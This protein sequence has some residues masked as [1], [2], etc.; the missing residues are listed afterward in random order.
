MAINPYTTPAQY[1]Y[2]P[3]NLMAFAEPLMKMQ[4][5]FDLTKAALE[6]S[7]VKAT[8]LQFGEDP[9]RAKELE[10]IYRTKRDELITNLMET[11]NYTQAASKLK[12]LNKLYQQD[13]ERIA[14]ETN[15]NTF[16][17]RDKEEAA[18][19]GKS[20]AQGGIT[21][22]QY[23]Q[24]RKEEIRKFEENQ[25]TNY[26]RD[27][28]NPLGTYNPITGKVGRETDMSKEL[29]ELMYKVAGD[30]EAKK[31]TS[32][33]QSLGIDPTVGDAKFKVSDY[34]KLSRQ[35]IEAKVEEYI[36]QQD[37]FKPFL[38]EKAYYD[39]NDIL[40]KKDEGAAFN[41][42]AD[43]LVNRNLNASENYLKYLES[44][45]KKKTPEYE[46]ALKTKAF[47][48]EQL[49]NPDPE[50]IRKLFTDSEMSRQYDASA[51]GKIFEVNN[52]KTNYTFR[53]LP[54]ED[55]GGDG[56]G[57]LFD[58]NAAVVNPTL[59]NR[60]YVGLE[61]T[62]NKGKTTAVKAVA[63]NNR[64]GGDKTFALREI[65]MGRVGS[66]LRK[67]M[68]ENPALAL[69]RQQQILAIRQRSNNAAEFH[70]NLWNAGF[71]S[72]DATNSATL[73]NVLSNSNNMQAIGNNVEGAM[74]D[75]YTMENAMN[76]LEQADKASLTD[77]QFLSEVNKLGAIQHA[78]PESVVEKFAKKVGK[79]VD[80][81]V[82]MGVVTT[83]T[84]F[85]PNGG[86]EFQE[87]LLDGNRIARAFGYKTLEE[88]VSKGV[89][90]TSKGLTGFGATLNNMQKEASK[91]LYSAQE[92]G[93]VFSNDTK[94][95][96]L[97]APMVKNAQD[98]ATFAPL[99]GTWDN[100][101]GFTEDGRPMA[102]TEI[103]GAPQISV[104]GNQVF[105]R[106]TYNYKN[107]VDV[108]GKGTLQNSVE[109]KIKPEQRSQIEES[110]NRIS[111]NAYQNKDASE[112]SNQVYQT[113]VRALYLMNTPSPAT[114]QSAQTAEVSPTS[115]EAVLETRVG[116][117][118]IRY[119]V[120]KRYVG[121]GIPDVYVARMVGPGG[122][123]PIKVDGQELKSNNIEK[124]HSVL[125]E[126]MDLRPE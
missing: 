87:F 25:G 91:R 52:S 66:D 5:K 77:K 80:E 105:L 62:F 16:L 37:R 50:I 22:E 115:R 61:N 8:A 20:A 35:E 67:K 55:E 75:Y 90:F 10:N 111:I 53:D 92:M 46:N 42:V 26:R 121:E 2:K 15:Y 17:E 109:V 40:Y 27:A 106:V 45:G 32:A 39:F 44:Q 123:Q 102:G 38:E 95:D 49:D 74:S 59:D 119:E 12:Q 79:S 69:P 114:R 11:K 43:E 30:I 122:R 110:L 82:R 18:R 94:V 3:L 73:F 9:I 89:D 7:D 1:Q 58:K 13:P 41:K 14:L 63:K 84:G 28:K 33:M 71:K 6:E 56:T 83:Q 103:V 23:S 98:L 19:V 113:A 99:R 126:L 96:K 68:E 48:L 54:S 104:R 72:A 107:P 118:G 51:L 36:K 31:F 85:K 117:N 81:L 64:V 21:K 29:E 24:W 65:S 97:L 124:I 93:Q 47:L 101:A 78:V 70:R 100:V 116:S 88:A 125:G 108:Y 86:G 4:E 57:G 76:L 112:A 60:T 120:V 34:E